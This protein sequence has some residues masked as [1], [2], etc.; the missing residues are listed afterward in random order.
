[1]KILLKTTIIILLSSQAIFAQQTKKIILRTNSNKVSIKECNSTYRNQW[2]LSPE[3]KPDV[4]VANLFEKT[5]EHVFFSQIDTLSFKVRPNKRYDFLI[6]KGR[7]SAYT[8]IS[9]YV[10]EKPTSVI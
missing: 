10:N 6:V 3:L 8:H 4:F 1:M 9:T 2:V 5:H 7:N